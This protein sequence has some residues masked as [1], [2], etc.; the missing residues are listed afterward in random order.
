[1][2]FENWFYLNKYLNYLLKTTN[3]LIITYVYIKEKNITLDFAEIL[4]I[5]INLL[6]RVGNNR[7]NI[8]YLVINLEFLIFNKPLNI[9]FGLLII[10]W[11]W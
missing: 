6:N 11:R 4:N 1:M 7:K 8:F 3:I 9:I 10:K 5:D 2:N